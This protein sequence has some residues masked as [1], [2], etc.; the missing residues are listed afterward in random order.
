[1]ELMEDI[2]W[3]QGEYFEVIDL[4]NMFCSALAVEESRLSCFYFGR[5]SA[6][7]KLPMGYLDNPALPITSATRI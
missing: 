6:N 3:T 1:M 4:A 2:Q 5:G 7:M